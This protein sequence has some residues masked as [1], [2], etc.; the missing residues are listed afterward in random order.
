MQITG[1]TLEFEKNK[2]IIYIYI[3]I[4]FRR[5]YC[6]WDL[7]LWLSPRF[8]RS[9]AT[10]AGLTLSIC[11]YR[12]QRSCGQ[13]NVFTGVCDSVHGR[14]V[15]ASVHVGI[16]DPPGSRHAPRADP[17]PGADTPPPPKKQAPAYGQ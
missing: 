5:N 2:Y 10:F 13:G 7:L 17:P 11:Y 1:Y 15:S 14:E 6:T 3:Y 8:P 16:P 4:L 9:P 12:P